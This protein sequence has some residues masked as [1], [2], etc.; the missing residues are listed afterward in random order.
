MHRARV[1]GFLA[2]LS[3][4]AGVPSRENNSIVRNDLPQ[5]L[6]G[7][8]FDEIFL[9]S[10]R[11]L[12]CLKGDQAESASAAFWSEFSQPERNALERFHRFFELRLEMMER[13]L[14]RG[15]GEDILNFWSHTVKDAALALNSFHSHLEKS[16]EQ[17]GK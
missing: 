13:G 8:W 7:L 12:D 5:V 10:R 4:H 2:F 3:G 15:D 9:P 11:Y 14:K 17:L 1:I 16:Y 6:S